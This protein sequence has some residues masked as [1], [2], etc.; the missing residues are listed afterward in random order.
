MG[1]DEMVLMP[2]FDPEDLLRLIEKH[3]TTH[4]QTVPT[5]FIRMLKLPEEERAKYDVSS[6]EFVVHAAAPC[7]PDIKQQMIDWWGPIINEYYGAT[8][9]GACLF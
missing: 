2:R 4:L 9:V 3:K 8:E 5:M 7:P 1:M 6:L